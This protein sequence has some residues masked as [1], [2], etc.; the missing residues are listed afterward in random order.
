MFSTAATP[1]PS[2]QTTTNTRHWLFRFVAHLNQSHAAIEQARTQQRTHDHH[3]DAVFRDA[4]RS[5]DD[6]TGIGSHQPKLPFFMQSGFGK[7]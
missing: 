5:R 7:R 3:P 6:A 4:G 1:R 2:V